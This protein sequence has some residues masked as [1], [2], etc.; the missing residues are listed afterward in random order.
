MKETT[1]VFMGTPSFA[2]PVLEKLI[3]NTNVLLVVSQPDK[4]VGRKHL[5]QATPVKEVALKHNIPV[6]QPVKI[7]E[8]YEAIKRLHPDLIITCAYGQI[9]PEALLKVP[10]IGSFNVHAS[11]LPK[12]RGGAPIHWALINGEKKTGV[13]IMYMDKGMDTG[14]MVSKVV[15]DIKPED[16]VGTLHEIL[17]VMGADLL[18]ETL[19]SI[20]SHT[21]KR[22]KQDEAKVSYAYNIKREDERLDLAK[23]GEEVI[24][25]I[26]GLNPFPTANILVNNE[27]YK[28]LEAT[29]ESHPK[30]SPGKVSSIQKDSIGIDVLDGTIYVTKLKPFGKKAMSTK[31]YLNGVSKETILNWQIN[32]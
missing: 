32:R 4:E 24:H 19:P 5:L 6:F 25:K 17:S 9:I 27:E 31:D 14:D 18:M 7:K 13:T 12:Y 30:S 10:K 16:N 2:V 26:R 22:E 21:N 11:L 29:F 8:D 28:I 3:L 23:K 1:V 15:Y 20:I